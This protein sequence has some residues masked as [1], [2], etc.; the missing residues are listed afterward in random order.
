[1]GM[2][3]W[4]KWERRAVFL[5]RPDQFPRRHRQER[6]AQCENDERPEHGHKRIAHDITGLKPAACRNDKEE[7]QGPEWLDHVGPAVSVTH[8]HGHFGNEGLRGLRC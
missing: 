5:A 4:M 3:Y 6:H 2:A 1:M 8:R 7:G